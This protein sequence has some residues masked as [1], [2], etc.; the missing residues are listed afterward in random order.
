MFP[1]VTK[2]LRLSAAVLTAIAIAICAEARPV[3]NWDYRQKFEMA[4]LVMIGRPIQTEDTSERIDL[5]GISVGRLHQASTGL[6]VIGIN[7][8][9]A[10]TSVRKGDTGTSEIVVHHYRLVSAKDELSANAANLVTFD[11]KKEAY[12]LLFLKR[13]S[14]GRYAPL[15]QTDPGMNSVEPVQKGQ[16]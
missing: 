9:F 16:K 13:E 14:D 8:R 10:V 15:D 2:R 11:P 6:P 3:A 1:F 12:F 4:D 7:T 5:P